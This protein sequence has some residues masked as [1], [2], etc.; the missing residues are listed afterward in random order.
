[1]HVVSQRA[2]V[3]RLRRTDCPLAFIAKPAV[4][5]SS[6]QER[7]GILVCVF[8]SSIA[9]PTDTPVYASGDTSRCHLQDSRAKM[10]SLSPFLWDSF[11]PY[12]MPVYP[13]A[14]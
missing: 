2:R 14:P 10:E 12:N 5:P 4:L 7:V 9:R 13:G 8:R 1:M 3:L 11:I 6:N